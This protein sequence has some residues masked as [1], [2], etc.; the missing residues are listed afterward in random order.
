[1]AIGLRAEWMK[2]LYHYLLVLPWSAFI[3]GFFLVYFALNLIFAALYLLGDG[4]VAD[5]RPGMFA[6]VFFFSVETLS[7]IG[8]GQ[9]LPRPFMATR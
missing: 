8:Y 7:T 9:M 3:A 2:D 6:D 4:A 5:V 1:M